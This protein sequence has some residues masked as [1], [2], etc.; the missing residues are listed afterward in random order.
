MRAIDSS[1]SL[2]KH[3]RSRT[4]VLLRSSK[5]FCALR[6]Q[7]VI[8]FIKTGAATWQPIG[9]KKGDLGSKG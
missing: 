9:A 4:R 1:G 7:Q 6:N 2:S 3:L 5:K 8:L